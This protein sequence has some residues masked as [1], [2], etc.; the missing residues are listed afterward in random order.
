MKS[1]NLAIILVPISFFPFAIASANPESSA[2]PEMVQLAQQTVICKFNDAT[3]PDNVPAFVNDIVQQNG[4]SVRH[5]YST[6]L[7]GFSS[8]MSLNAAQAIQT[9]N[10]NID[11][12]VAN[13]LVSAGGTKVTSGGKG[14]EG[15][16]PGQVAPQIIPEGITRVGGPINGIGLTAWIIDSGIDLDH[17]D[18]NVDATRGFDA[19]NAVAKGLS[20]FDDVNGHGTH[21]SGILAAIDNDIDVVGVAAGATVV[22]VRVLAA[23]NFGYADDV[24]AGMDYVAA[25]ASINDVANMSVWGWAHNRAFHDAAYNLAKYM[26]VVTISG[27][28]S[29]D[30]NAEPT[31]PGHVEHK[32][33][34][35]VSAI[36]HGDV[37]GDFS[38]WGNAGDWTNCSENY[39]NDSYPCAT[40]DYAAPGKDVISL[41]PGGGLAEWFG[42][43]MAAPHVAAI[44]LLLQNR[45]IP[46]TS[47]GVAINDPDSRSDPIIHY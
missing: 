28:G 26:T 17:P 21:V 30:I 7:K 14:G 1:V 38:N 11:Y 35:T 34:F 25:N 22:P 41:K 2:P 24:I 20:S 15:G 31:E 39:P 33:L 4:A 32:H 37:F 42:T 46:P 29:A 16:K 6:V 18:L 9:H 8:Q 10:P 13:S 23:S 36:D 40:V 27:N 5:M 19:V 43:S 45:N 47:N 44:L 3:L 12:C